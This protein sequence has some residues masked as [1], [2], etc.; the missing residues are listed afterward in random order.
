MKDSILYILYADLGEAKIGFH[1]KSSCNIITMMSTVFSFSI[2]SL[3]SII[4]GL[5]NYVKMISNVRGSSRCLLIPLTNVRRTSQYLLLPLTDIIGSSK[6]L[7]IPL[8]LYVFSLI[9]KE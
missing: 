5:A 4:V 8:T 3:I 2:S 6:C 1:V 9:I 7:L